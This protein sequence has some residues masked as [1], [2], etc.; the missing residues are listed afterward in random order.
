MH[1]I[2][3]YT[4]VGGFLLIGLSPLQVII[5]LIFSSFFIALLLVANGYAGSKYG[6]PFSMQLRSNHMVMSVRNCQAYYVVVIAGI[7]WFGLQTFAGSQALH[8]LLNKIFPGFN[9][10]GHGMTILG[11]TIPALIAFL[12]FWAI[13][14]AIGFWRW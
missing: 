11:I 3:N 14:F 2:P 7:A 6:I 8:I 9:D 4:A 1:N 13:S 10:I 12:I 5:A